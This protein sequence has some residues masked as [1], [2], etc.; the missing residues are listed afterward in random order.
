MDNAMTVLRDSNRGKAICGTIIQRGVNVEFGYLPD[1]VRYEDGKRVEYMI[2]AQYDPA[3]KTITVNIDLKNEPGNVIAPYLAHEGRHA[4]LDRG[5]QK[6]SLAEEYEAHKA[7][8]DVWEEVKGNARH[9]GHENV[10]TII[11]WGVQEAKAKIR[12]TYGDDY[13]SDVFE[14]DMEVEHCEC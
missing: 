9:R 12:G 14:S 10:A 7:Q 6:A 1:D 8:A 2:A 11:S 4:Q 13:F 3:G 5:E